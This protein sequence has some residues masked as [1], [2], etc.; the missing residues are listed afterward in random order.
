MTDAPTVLVAG[1]TGLQGGAVAR[2]LLDREV[3][4]RGLTRTPESE[5][6][7]ALAELGA[8]VVVGDFED[9]DSLAS[10]AHGAD[11]VFVMGTPFGTDPETETRQSTTLIDAAQTAG[12]AHIVYSS[13]ASALEHT[14]IPHFESKAAVERYLTGLDEPHTVIAPAAFLTD[15]EQDAI[16]AGRIPSFIPADVELQQIAIADLGA[17]ASLVLTQPGRFAGKRIEV[18]S[19]QASTAQV[20]TE[21]GQRLGYSITVD[22]LPLEI[23]REQGGDDMARMVEFFT[24]GGYSIDI[25]ALHAAYPE[26][27]WLGF[28]ER[29]D[30]ALE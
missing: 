30:A 12:V 9:P 3:P 1:A 19:L 20:A 27:D 13:V 8:Q 15:L 25:P 28:H 14:H 18:A 26:I 5:A 21:L 4:V 29:I 16:K 22:E 23:I 11:A 24:A 17:F 2:A 6:A 7:G 10:A